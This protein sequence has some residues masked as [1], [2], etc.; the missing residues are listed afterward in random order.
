MGFT[1]FLKLSLNF[2]RFWPS[3]GFFV[4]S[5]GSFIFLSLSIKQ[6]PLGTAYAVWTGLGACGTALIGMLFFNEPLEAGRLF[7]LALIITAVIGLKLVSH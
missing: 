6:I 2:T 5:I 1:T 4:L 7:F 3:V